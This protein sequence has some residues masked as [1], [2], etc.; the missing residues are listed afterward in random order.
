MP[1]D[2]IVRRRE[3]GKPR[4]RQLHLR[5]IANSPVR[6]RRMTGPHWAGLACSAGA[7]GKEEIELRG[8]RVDLAARLAAG[9]KG[10]N[11]PVAEMIDQ[12]LAKD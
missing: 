1:C 3:G 9:G 2:L 6:G 4:S 10:M 8:Q 11:P 7:D 5:Q 12:G